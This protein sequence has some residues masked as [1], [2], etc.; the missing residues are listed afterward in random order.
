MLVIRLQR[1]GRENDP[2]YHIVVSEKARA[3]KKGSL[4][5]L[6]HYLP[7]RTT[8]TFTFD[9]GRIEHWVKQGAQPSDTVARLLRKNGVKGME[10]FIV[11]YAKQKPKGAEVETAAPAAAPSAPATAA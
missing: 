1:T 9:A 5:N 8:P 11:R 2:T 6:G 7:S 3:V 10:K 4:E